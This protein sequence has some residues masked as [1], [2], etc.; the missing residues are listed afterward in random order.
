MKK[1]FLTCVMRDIMMLLKN[2]HEN[3]FKN[4]WRG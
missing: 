4:E 1:E 3:E 2:I